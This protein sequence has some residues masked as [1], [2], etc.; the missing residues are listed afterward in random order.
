MRQ[1]ENDAGQICSHDNSLMEMEK[2]INPFFS[3][4]ED[5]ISGLTS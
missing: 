3:W 4:R 2:E 1:T 5:W